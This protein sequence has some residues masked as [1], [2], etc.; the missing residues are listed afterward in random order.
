MEQP[1]IREKSNRTSVIQTFSR[2]PLG[3]F[4]HLPGL[5]E[6]DSLLKRRALQS[7]KAVIKLAFH[8]VK[9][10]NLIR[11]THTARFLANAPR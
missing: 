9:K 1:Y 2:S 7:R 3:F 6:R 8:T 4:F 5:R 11:P 10:S